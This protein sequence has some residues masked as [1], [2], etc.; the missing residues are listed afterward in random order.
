MKTILIS[1]LISITAISAFAQDENVI[2]SF[3]TEKN[4]VVQLIFN[5]SDSIFTFRLLSRGKI[6][7]EI[8][9]DLTDTDTIFTVYGYHRGGGAENA[10]MDYNDVTFSNNG[11]AYDIYYVWAISEENP[12]IEHDPTYGLKIFREGIESVDLKGKK[13]ITGSAYGYSFYDLLPVK[14]QE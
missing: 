2:Y 12:D 1:F 14:R 10:A 4:K 7:L 8:K 9:D 13:V 11:T 3:Q 6:E 5:E